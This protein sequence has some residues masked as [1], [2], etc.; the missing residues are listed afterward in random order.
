M[1]L[2]LEQDQRSTPIGID[3]DGYLYVVTFSPDGEYVVGGD[4]EK[5]RVWR[6]RDGKRMGMIKTN[7]CVRWVTMSK[8]GN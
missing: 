5:V 1:I 3:Q 2:T 6:V 4:P 7:K 8:D